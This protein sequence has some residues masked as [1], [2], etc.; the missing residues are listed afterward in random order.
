[1]FPA[2]LLSVGLPLGVTFLLASL[3]FA[4]W[5]A[6]QGPR[7]MLFAGVGGFVNHLLVL[8]TG[9]VWTPILS[10]V[11]YDFVAGLLIARGNVSRG[12]PAPLEEKLA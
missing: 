1:V 2:V 12:G 11:A 5:H 6:A 4:L 9:T 10:H 3:V 7:G 8:G